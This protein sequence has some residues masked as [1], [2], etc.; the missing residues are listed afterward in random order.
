MCETEILFPFW[1]II[2]PIFSYSITYASL[3]STLPVT[4]IIDGSN[5]FKIE[6][7]ANKHSTRSSSKFN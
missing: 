2:L 7:K 6:F 3:E 4:L 1:T 5:D